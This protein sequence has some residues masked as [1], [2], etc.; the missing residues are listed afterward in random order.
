MNRLM[1]KRKIL[2]SI[3]K[4][5]LA[6]RMTH[7]ELS[8]EAGVS[9]ATIWRWEQKPDSMTMKPVRKIEAALDRLEKAKKEGKI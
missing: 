6:L 9:S 1:D 4:R 2:A 8:A 7:A 5:C 3:K